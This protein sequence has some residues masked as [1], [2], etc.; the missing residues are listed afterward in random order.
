M[1]VL[2]LLKRLGNQ[3]TTHFGLQSVIHNSAIK[4]QLKIIN[5][6][7]EPFIEIQHEVI[8]S[9]GNSEI[10]EF[11]MGFEPTTLRDLVGHSNH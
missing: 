2:Y 10:S 11:Q 5:K 7:I 3:S 8:A 6:M 1:N 4:N 9:R